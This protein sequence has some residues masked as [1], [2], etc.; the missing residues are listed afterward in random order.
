MADD[1]WTKDDPDPGDFDNGLEG[2]DPQ[3]VERHA[4]DPKAR[5]RTI[6]ERIV[7]DHADALQRLADHESNDNI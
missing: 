5:R 3:F 7:E 1:P 6:G 4:G 2:I